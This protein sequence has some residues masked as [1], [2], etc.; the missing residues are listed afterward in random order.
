MKNK[1][2]DWHLTIL[3]ASALLVSCATAPQ[4]ALF[5][6]PAYGETRLETLALLPVTYNA[7][8]DQPKEV[9]LSRMI[10]S[11]VQRTLQKKGFRTILVGPHYGGDT[12]DLWAAEPARLAAMAINGSEAVVLIHVDFHV[13]I[14]FGE[15]RSGDPFSTV[16]IYGKSRLVSRENPRELW[17]DQG[18]GSDRSGF[19]GGGSPRLREAVSDLA[20]NLFETLPSSSR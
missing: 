17:R 3:I 20:E 5:I 8:Y 4:K 14:D 2:C 15:F 13:G 16:E 18:R 11:R 7:D 12:T 10:R 19:F 1:F 9:N 6:D